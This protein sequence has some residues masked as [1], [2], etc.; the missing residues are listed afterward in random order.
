[1]H[2][3]HHPPRSQGG[4]NIPEHLYVCSPS[5]H[6]CGWHKADPTLAMTPHSSAAGRVS[7]AKQ[8]RD[9]LGMFGRDYTKMVE[10]C[11]KGAEAVQAKLGPLLGLTP[12]EISEK[13]AKSAATQRDRGSGMFGMTK[14]AKTKRSREAVR[15]TNSQRWVD[16]DHPELG[17]HSAGTLVMMQKRRNYPHGK[18]NRLRVYPEIT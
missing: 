2:V 11:R 16:P 5:V 15:K 1:M 18:S 14:E 8:Y 6:Y 4:R 12:S 9:R 13:N 17:A 3:H 10:D 7:G